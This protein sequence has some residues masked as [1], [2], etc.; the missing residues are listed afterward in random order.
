MILEN[1]S[2][3]EDFT[4]RE[5]AQIML[6]AKS[7][8]QSSEA[9]FVS[10]ESAP[11]AVVPK[12]NDKLEIDRYF[13]ALVKLDGSDLHLKVDQPP[14]MR[15]KGSLQRL[16][17]PPIGHE[18]MKS[19]CFPMLDDR[20]MKILEDEGGADFAYSALIGDNKVAISSEPSLSARITWNGGPES[21]QH[22]T[23]L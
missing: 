7:E 23:K 9:T 8:A 15:V 11:A 12:K 22:D 10:E 16:K 3:L 6:D 20:Q 17:A 4:Y 2:K 19:L 21:Q 5:G 13:E 14:I 1:V 18:Q